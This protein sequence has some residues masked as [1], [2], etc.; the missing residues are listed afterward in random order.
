MASKKSM[1]KEAAKT[2]LDLMAEYTP[3]GAVIY[4][5]AGT[6]QLFFVKRA[7]HGLVW[8]KDV[9]KA[10][11]FNTTMIASAVRDALSIG[12]NFYYVSLVYRN[13]TTHLTTYDPN[14]PWRI[15]YA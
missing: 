15:D 12:R 13:P 5:V 1:K 11:M 6:K 4:R 3:Y 9:N 2:A 8:S 14:S 7:W 10:M